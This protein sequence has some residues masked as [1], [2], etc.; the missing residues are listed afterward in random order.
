[1]TNKNE[2]N[3]KGRPMKKYLVTLLILSIPLICFSKELPSE[4]KNNLIYLKPKLADGTT[5]TFFTDTG[6]GWNAISREL[7]EKKRN[8]SK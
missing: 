3:A 8:D 1:M 4:F 7:S 6:G 2:N 5:L